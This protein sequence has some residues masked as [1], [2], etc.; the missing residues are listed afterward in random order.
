MTNEWGLLTPKKKKIGG[1]KIGYT[2]AYNM[3]SNIFYTGNFIYRG[4]LYKG[5]HSPMITMVEFDRVQTLLKEH[6]KPR[7]KTHEFAY[8]CGAFECGE[9]G[10]SIVGIEKVKFI[11]ST[12]ETKVYVFY[13]CGHKKSVVYCSQK[14]NINEI[15]IEEQ[16]QAEIHKYTIDSDFLH[17]ALEVMK[18][19]NTLETVTKKD[20]KENVLKTIETKQEELSK[21]IQ[22]AVKGFISD[23]EFKESRVK[24]DKIITNLN[25]QLNMAEEDKNNDLIELTEKAFYYS[26]YALI[27]LKNSDK[28]TRKE[29]IKSLGMNREI[30]DKIVSIKAFEWYLHIQKTYSSLRGQ[31]AGPEPEVRSKQKTVYDFPNLRLVMRG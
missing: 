22:M 16:I 1:A 15:E 13:L 7:A 9:C 23:E 18:D 2:S 17:W 5:D 20:I 25:D 28:R 4:I 26:T 10:H 21:L 11:K 31:L 29:I 3:F 24:L 14:Y 8:G 19:N 30:K 12:K 6:G 27:A